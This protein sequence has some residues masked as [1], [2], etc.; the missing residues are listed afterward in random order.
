MSL[1]I[2]SVL[3]ALSKTERGYWNYSSAVQKMN[4][5]FDHL[6]ICQIVWGNADT[7]SYR[8]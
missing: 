2:R 5:R 1:N 3:K 4:S 8:S 6:V 7:G